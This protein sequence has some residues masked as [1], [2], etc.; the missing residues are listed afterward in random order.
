MDS[1]ESRRVKIEDIIAGIFSSVLS[2]VDVGLKSQLLRLS[3][4]LP[5][6]VYY[7]E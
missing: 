2:A 3:G 6:C 7:N 1:L 5:N 4:F